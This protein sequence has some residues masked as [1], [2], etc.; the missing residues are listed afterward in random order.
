MFAILFA[1]KKWQHFLMGRHFTIRTDHK[2][3]K[4]LM[5]QK[6]TTPSQ[7]LWLSQLMAYDFDIT[8]KQGSENGAADALSRVPS[9]ELLCLAISSVSADLNKQICNSY[10]GDPGLQK[11][12]KEL[13]QNPASHMNFTWEKGLLRRKGKVVVG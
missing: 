9:H 13:T 3:L 2:P 7:H 1:V 12:I 10:A 4:Y 8:Y 5:E 11:I 6:V